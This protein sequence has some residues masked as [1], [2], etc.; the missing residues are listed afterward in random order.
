MW[1]HESAIILDCDGVVEV[2]IEF[3]RAH[4]NWYTYNGHYIENNKLVHSFI[5]VLF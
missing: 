5:P 4:P 1:E 3:I 2:D